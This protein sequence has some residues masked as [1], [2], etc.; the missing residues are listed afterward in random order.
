V[1]KYAQEITEQV[2]MEERVAEKA[3][4]MTASVLTLTGSIDEIARSSTE[5]TELAVQTQ[6]NAEQG[7]QALAKSIEAIGLIQKS[8]SAIAEIVQVI[9]DIAGQT[10]LLAFNASIEAAR[11]GEHGVGFSVVAG[12]VRKLAERSSEAASDI[13]KLIAESAERVALGSEVSAKAQDSFERIVG[14]V[15]RTTEAIGQ[16]ALAT[17]SQ[18][19]ASSA[20]TTLITQLSGE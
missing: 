3:E 4:Q 11:A 2:A 6:T 1:I 10:N 12:E 20:V 15:A 13:A 5:A 19:Q 16:I 8:S 7:S 9:G 14:S 17:R 18:Q